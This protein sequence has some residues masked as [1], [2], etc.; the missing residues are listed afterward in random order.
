MKLALAAVFAACCSV[1]A[2]IATFEGIVGDQLLKLDRTSK[3]AAEIALPNPRRRPNDGIERVSGH[4]RLESSDKD[5][6]LKII[7]PW[8]HFGAFINAGE[9]G[10]KIH[11]MGFGW[12][13]D[14]LYFSI[15]DDGD[16]HASTSI[17]K[18]LFHQGIP[19]RLSVTVPFSKPGSDQ[20]NGWLT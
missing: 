1:H 6:E 18:K 19:L 12:G 8:S 9:D 16:H 20:T 13:S 17:E 3:A 11:A 5:I 14:T 2:E 4:C 7:D 10:G 15:G